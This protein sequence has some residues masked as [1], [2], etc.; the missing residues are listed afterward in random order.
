MLHGNKI[1]HGNVKRE[2]LSVLFEGG[3]LSSSPFGLCSQDGEG[4]WEREL[5]FA[6]LLIACEM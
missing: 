3:Y 5:F 6:S 2:F 1:L 4:G